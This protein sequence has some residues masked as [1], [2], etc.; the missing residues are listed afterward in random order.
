M[1]DGKSNLR[2]L[3]GILGGV[4]GGSD[5]IASRDSDHRPH[6]GIQFSTKKF[7]IRQ[8]NVLNKRKLN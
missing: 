8:K 3:L 1:C 5:I 4:V 7:V 6:S 2:K